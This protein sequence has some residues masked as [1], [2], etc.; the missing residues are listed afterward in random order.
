MTDR[1]IDI[2]IWPQTGEMSAHSHATVD[3][4]DPPRALG[5]IEFRRDAHSKADALADILRIVWPDVRATWEQL[6]VHDTL[7][8]VAQMVTDGTLADADAEVLLEVLRER[9]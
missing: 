8:V 1:R 4:S 5:S 2:T 7:E 9:S 6:G 3:G